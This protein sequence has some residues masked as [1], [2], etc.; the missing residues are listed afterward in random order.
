MSFLKS[1]LLELASGIRVSAAHKG[2]I[3]NRESDGGGSMA[4]YFDLVGVQISDN[5]PITSSIKVTVVAHF[6]IKHG[7]PVVDGIEVV[8]VEAGSAQGRQLKQSEVAA[9][10]EQDKMVIGLVKAI[11]T[12]W[13]RAELENVDHD[14]VGYGS[15]Y[16]Q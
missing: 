3:R 11:F 4:G 7:G 2:A 15:S 1:A 6:E 5:P 12:K 8:E 13:L 10:V 9:R 14:P 16:Q